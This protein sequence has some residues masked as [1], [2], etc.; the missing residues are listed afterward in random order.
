M[1]GE[2]AQEKTVRQT[3]GLPHGFFVRTGRGLA[4]VVLLVVTLVLVTLVLAALIV[5]LLLVVALV[6]ITLVLV[7][8]TVVLHKDT[9]FQCH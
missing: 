2:E 5:V 3:L 9:S 7:V 6:L 4:V 1:S 8:L